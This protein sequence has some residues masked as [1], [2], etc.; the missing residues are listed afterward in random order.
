M[1][2]S[3]SKK[4][5][6]NNL[7]VITRIL[8]EFDDCASVELGYEMGCDFLVWRK[9]VDGRRHSISM[10]IPRAWL[11]DSRHAARLE[12]TTRIFAHTVIKEL[13]LEMT[14]SGTVS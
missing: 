8:S 4:R 3:V 9:S 1:Q 11:A 6:P 12:E 2:L 13:E 7:D 5:P 10:P 14:A